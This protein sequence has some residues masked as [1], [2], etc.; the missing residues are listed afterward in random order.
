[1]FFNFR[2]SKEVNLLKKGETSC[3]FLVI[4]ANKTLEN[5][6][7]FSQAYQNHW[8]LISQQTDDFRSMNDI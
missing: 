5:E 3:R 7:R 2:V 4:D 6:R 1:M 8:Y